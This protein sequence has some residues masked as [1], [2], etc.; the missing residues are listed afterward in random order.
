M[1]M[2]ITF[3]HMCIRCKSRDFYTCPC[4]F[5][6]LRSEKVCKIYFTYLRCKKNM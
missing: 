1:E 4:N 6:Y 2:C 5:T 3:V